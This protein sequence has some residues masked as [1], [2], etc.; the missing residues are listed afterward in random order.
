MTRRCIVPVHGSKIIKPG[1]LQSIL[2]GAGISTEEFL[3][4]LK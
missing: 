4:L 3:N 2:R 1:T